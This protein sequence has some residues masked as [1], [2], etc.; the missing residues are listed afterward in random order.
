[1]TGVTVSQGKRQ[2]TKQVKPVPLLVLV[3]NRMVSVLVVF[4]D[5][6]YTDWLAKG[7]RLLF[8][9]IINTDEVLGPS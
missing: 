1:M 8:D 9:L 2:P 7:F 5:E 3:F 4:S 6:A